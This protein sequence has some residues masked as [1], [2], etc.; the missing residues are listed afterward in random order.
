MAKD[1]QEIKSILQ[2]LPLPKLPTPV[3]VRGIEIDLDRFVGGQ[4]H[5]R[6]TG[7][8]RPAP[9]R[10]LPL[11]GQGAHGPAVRRAGAHDHALAKTM[12]DAG[13]QEIG[14]DVRHPQGHDIDPRDD[15]LEP[16]LVVFRDPAAVGRHVAVGVDFLQVFLPGFGF[17]SCNIGQ[18][19]G[20][21]IAWKQSSDR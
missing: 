3:N 10:H 20:R 8:D 17:R 11:V 6:E 19:S 5:P 14:L 2:A 12:A 15:L 9:E 1:L 18:P 16:G 4:F 21:Q 7:G 13:N